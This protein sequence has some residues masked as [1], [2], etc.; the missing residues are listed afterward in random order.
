[1]FYKKTSLIICACAEIIFPLYLKNWYVRGHGHQSGLVVVPFLGRSVLYLDVLYIHIH[2]ELLV[3]HTIHLGQI[4]WLSLCV[5]CEL[6][7]SHDLRFTF[8]QLLAY[9][10][11]ALNVEGS[12]PATFQ[13]CLSVVVVKAAHNNQQ[14]AGGRGARSS[15]RTY[16]Q[17]IVPFKVFFASTHVAI[18][19]MICWYTWPH[20]AIAYINR[21][22]MWRSIQYPQLAV[23][24]HVRCGICRANT[25]TLWFVW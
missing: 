7:N 11:T 1:M 19:I 5:I 24:R 9:L 20:I 22:W 6:N 3:F 18:W 15:M 2:Y 17:P 8:L 21:W 16:Q 23:G 12:L 14:N 25:M 13:R 4:T 10:V